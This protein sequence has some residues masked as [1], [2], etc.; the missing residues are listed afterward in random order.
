MYRPVTYTCAFLSILFLY[1]SHGV[2][3]E[4]E[5]YDFNAYAV[6]CCFQSLLLCSF[7]DDGGKANSEVLVLWFLFL[8]IK[9]H[10][11]SS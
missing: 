9:F 10:C 8:G 1:C 6:F 11:A 2:G 5:G 4:C 7:L 3:I